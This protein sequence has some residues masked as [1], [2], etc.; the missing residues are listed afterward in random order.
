MNHV[1][2]RRTA[3]ATGMLT[4]ISL[5]ATLQVLSAERRDCVVETDSFDDHGELILEDGQVNA[6]QTGPLSGT[7][8]VLEILQWPDV[9]VRI[10]SGR[11]GSQRDIF[12]PLHQL[13]I[14]AYRL[15]DEDQAAG[16]LPADSRAW[17]QS[18]IS[19]IDGAF[20]ALL[21]PAASDYDYASLLIHLAPVGGMLTARSS[22]STRVSWST[23]MDRH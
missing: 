15:D 13:L 14:D 1:V 21:E 22:T 10:Q 23:G 17:G 4:G 11:S 3:G 20:D 18:A 19:A 8:A 6:A 7:E 16:D 9:T 2:S 5:P 12:T